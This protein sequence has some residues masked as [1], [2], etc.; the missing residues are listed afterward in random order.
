MYSHR[1]ALWVA[2]HLSL[3]WHDHLKSKEINTQTLAPS[4]VQDSSFESSFKVFEAN[5]ASDLMCNEWLQCRN[6]DCVCWRAF[7]SG[8]YYVERWE[9]R[10]LCTAYLRQKH[11]MHF[12]LWALR[13][14]YQDRE[15]NIGPE[16]G[17]MKPRVHI[18]FYFNI[19]GKILTLSHPVNS[20]G[21]PKLVPI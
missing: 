5:V 20:Y 10:L 1:Q 14:Q 3:F 4:G 2:W 16:G 9:S 18:C 17:D 8:F 15:P 6:Q 11:Q 19:L 13:R 12:M 7:S 21:R